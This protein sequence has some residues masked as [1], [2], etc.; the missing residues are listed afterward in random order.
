[1]S[2]TTILLN[3]DLMLRVRQLARANGTTMT[4]IIREA[5]EAYVGQQQQGRVLSF[6]G[7]GKSGRRSVSKNAEEILR[8]K[9]D[10]RKGW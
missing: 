3:D 9:A 7:V 1:M 4:D 6:A 8:R 2:R 10:R 5:L